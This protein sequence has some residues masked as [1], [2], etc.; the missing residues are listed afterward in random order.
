MLSENLSALGCKDSGLD[1]VSQSR[2]RVHRAKG[3]EVQLS[4]VRRIPFL[5]CQKWGEPIFTEI[6]GQSGQGAQQHN[7]AP[8]EE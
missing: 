2:S 8:S 1:R 5:D 4:P 7:P 6:E 3:L